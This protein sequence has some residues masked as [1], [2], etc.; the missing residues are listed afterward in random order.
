[1]PQA[2]TNK[3][4]HNKIKYSKKNKQQNESFGQLVVLGFD[5]TVFTPTPYQRRRLQR[6]SKEF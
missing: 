1:M 2:K 5:I 4:S 6:P 3:I